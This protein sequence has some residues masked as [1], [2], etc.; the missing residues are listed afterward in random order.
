MSSSYS[1]NYIKD[2]GKGLKKKKPKAKGTVFWFVD[3]LRNRL[4]LS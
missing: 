3:L 1:Y 4:N 2:L